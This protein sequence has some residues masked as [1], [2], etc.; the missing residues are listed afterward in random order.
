MMFSLESR[1]GLEGEVL[2]DIS[3]VELFFSLLGKVF[4]F[5]FGINNF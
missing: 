4:L 5:R 2:F 1:F 3:D